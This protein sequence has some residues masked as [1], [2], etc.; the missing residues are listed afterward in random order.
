MP[1]LPL[2]TT[3]KVPHI[4]SFHVSLRKWLFWSVLVVSAAVLLFNLA[5]LVYP[6][7]ENSLPVSVNGVIDGTEILL[8]ESPEAKKIVEDEE[9]NFGEA[10]N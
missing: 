1:T 2:A 9:V 6:S 4:P 8:N 7:L 3:P 10:E 5:S